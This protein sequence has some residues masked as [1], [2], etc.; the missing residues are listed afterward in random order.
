MLDVSIL[1]LQCGICVFNLIL[2][3]LPV[4]FCF[5]HYQFTNRT[6]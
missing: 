1:S 6:I 3:N 2:Y 5:S 4:S